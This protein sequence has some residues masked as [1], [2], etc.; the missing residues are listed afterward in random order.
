[1]GRRKW[2]TKKE[3]DAILK[4]Y[5]LHK[6]EFQPFGNDG[7]CYVSRYANG[8]MI[9]I[10]QEIQYGI[11]K[12]GRILVAHTKG[13]GKISFNDIWER[14]SNGGFQFC[15]RNPLDVPLSDA[16]YIKDL[17]QQISGFKL[18]GRK[19]ETN[20]EELQLQAETLITENAKLREQVEALTAENQKLTAGF[21]HNARGAGR[22]PN[23]DQIEARVRK[24][25]SLLDD[26][27]TTAEIQKAMGISR[28][29]V[30]RYKRLMKESYNN[31]NKA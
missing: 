26:G 12:T 22:K 15:F 11:E 5:S 6:D 19:L 8:Y 4:T 7:Y 1:M 27:K 30:F 10:K 24:V 13:N 29:S 21:K 23:P 18:A 25:Q 14:D 9:S 3:V 2:I 31:C 20:L 17:E 16:F 28:S